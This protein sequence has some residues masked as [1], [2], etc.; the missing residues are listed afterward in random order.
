MHGSVEQARGA[1]PVWAE[2][3]AEPRLGCGSS[4]QTHSHAALVFYLEGRAVV[5]QRGPLELGAGDVHLV[6]AG[7]PH[8]MLACEGGSAW[9]I[10]FDAACWAPTELAGLLD[11]FERARSGSTAVVH[12]PAE[13]HAHLASLCAE[14]HGESAHPGAHAELVQKSLLALVLAEVVRASPL[15]AGDGAGSWIADALRFVEHN[16]LR[17]ISLGDVAAAVHRSP[18][19]VT[20]AVKRATGRSVGAWIVEGRHAEARR[21]LLHTDEHVEIVA[22]RVGYADPTH[23]IRSFRRA[24]GVTPAVWRSRARSAR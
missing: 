17:P 19:H 8:R 1:R 7:E 21:R 5:D 11:P 20:T 15:A 9:G 14:L 2:R 22:E 3:L 10:G 24:H 23:F 6:P 12:I 4:R 18:S 16:C 13:R